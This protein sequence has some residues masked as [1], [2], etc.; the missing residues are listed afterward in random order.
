MA[1]HLIEKFE[2][3]FCLYL[4]G[5]EITT[6]RQQLAM[7]AEVHWLAND[8]QLLKYFQ[9]IEKSAKTVPQLEV[10]VS[11][12]ASLEILENQK[13]SLVHITITVKMKGYSDDHI[14][15]PYTRLLLGVVLQEYAAWSVFKIYVK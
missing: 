13:E 11:L 6:A 8:L 12:S 7:H 4:V 3:H 1:Q 2:D 10:E 5:A 14:S 15:F 9:S